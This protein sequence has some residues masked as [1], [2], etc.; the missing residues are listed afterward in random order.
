MALV[1]FGVTGVALIFGTLSVIY[2]FIKLKALMLR[3]NFS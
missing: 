1:T 3:S 2:K